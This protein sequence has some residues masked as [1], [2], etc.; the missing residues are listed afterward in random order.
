[1]EKTQYLADVTQDNV[2]RQRRNSTA[3]DP[4]SQ[5]TRDHWYAILVANHE[6]LV[7]ISINLTTLMFLVV[8]DLREA[9]KE[10]HKFPFSPGNE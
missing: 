9:Q 8:S 7:P 3:L 4:N 2:E 1:M 10:T 5:E 6:R